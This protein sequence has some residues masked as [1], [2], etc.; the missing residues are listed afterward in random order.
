ML[1]FDSMCS[2]KVANVDILLKLS[3][4][5][6]HSLIIDGIQDFYEILVRFRDIYLFILF[7]KGQSDISITKGG[8]K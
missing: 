8:S 4:G 1:N 2:L 6:F 3:S 7:L 5:E